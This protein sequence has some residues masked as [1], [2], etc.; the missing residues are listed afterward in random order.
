MISWSNEL[1]LRKAIT[2]NRFEYKYMPCRFGKSCMWI[3]LSQ[4][5]YEEMP[6][7]S[8]HPAPS[9]ET[10]R[11]VADDGI[12]VTTFTAVT[13]VGTHIDAPIHLVEGGTTIDE[14][15]LD[16]FT[17]E[18][19]VVDVSRTEANEISR[20]EFIEAPGEVRDGDIVLV[21][22]GWCHRYGEASYTPHPWLSED[23]AEWLV[24][25]EIKLVGID[26]TTPDLPTSFRE[27]GWME[28]PVHRTLLE[29][30]VLIA[31][32]LGG[33]KAVAGDRLKVYAFPLKI[34]DGDGAQARFVAHVPE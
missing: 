13:H 10:L 28:Y 32:H 7:A 11:C 3:D 24:D 12:N 1:A 2:T 27:A 19:V 16:R 5:F 6:Y 17:G 25:R 14:L 22:T 31:E 23:L 8:V 15:S 33:L 9:F 21:Y 18:G 30:D 20:S 26:T 29:N 4:D 34:R